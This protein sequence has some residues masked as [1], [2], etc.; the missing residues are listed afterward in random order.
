MWRD[1]P[2][3]RVRCGHGWPG[4]SPP[5]SSYRSRRRSGHGSRRFAGGRDRAPPGRARRRL[6]RASHSRHEAPE[7]R[8]C[9]RRPTAPAQQRH[10]LRAAPRSRIRPTG[11]NSGRKTQPNNPTC[12]TPSAAWSIP[13][14][15]AGR[16]SV[17]RFTSQFR[18]KLG[19][20][21]P[22]SPRSARSRQQARDASRA[23]AARLRHRPPGASADWRC[24]ERSPPQPSAGCA[25]CDR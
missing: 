8:L 3:R 18:V 23:L 15:A 13:P 6:G 20:I 17:C 24:R 10:R 2:I 7:Q 19:T 22:P 14:G 11:W 1:R 21:R 16:F 9:G 5:R 12:R 4:S 25:S